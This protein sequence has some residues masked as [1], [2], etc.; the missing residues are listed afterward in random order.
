MIDEKD[1]MSPMVDILNR[2]TQEGYTTQ[3]KASSKGI[4]SMR[5]Q[6]VFGPEVVEINH[7]YRFEGESDPA[8]TSIVYAIETHSGEKGTLIDS[9]GMYSDPDVEKFIK[10]V[11]SIKK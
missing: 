11:E 10:Q 9:F 5:T 2:L 7:F 8:D 1:Q 4:C 3:F 6:N